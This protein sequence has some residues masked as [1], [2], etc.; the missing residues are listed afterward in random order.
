[1]TVNFINVI[2]NN[3]TNYYEKK[4]LILYVILHLNMHYFKKKIASQG[5]NFYT[6][7]AVLNS[8]AAYQINKRKNIRH[9]TEIFKIQ[10]KI[11][12]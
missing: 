8:D 2:C 7:H 10:I 1:M 9:H 6:F 11:N 5:R 12:L 4:N 3:L